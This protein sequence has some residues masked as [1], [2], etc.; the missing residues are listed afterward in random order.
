MEKMS[1]SVRRSAVQ[2]ITED[3]RLR[4]NA[5][6]VL[7]HI[8]RARVAAHGGAAISLA[9]TDPVTATA[10]TTARRKSLQDIALVSG[11]AAKVAMDRSVEAMRA[12]RHAKESD[13]QRAARLAGEA[14]GERSTCGREGAGLSCPVPLAVPDIRQFPLIP[15]SGP[16]DENRNLRSMRPLAN[17]RLSTWP[18]ARALRGGGCGDCVS[19]GSYRDSG[20]SS[21]SFR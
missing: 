12:E 4:Q 7:V 8:A 13:E 20:A 2:T 3:E 10:S 15:P 18:G 19:E 6:E 14:E 9:R 17:F 16:S 5:R 11:A 21:R 1:K